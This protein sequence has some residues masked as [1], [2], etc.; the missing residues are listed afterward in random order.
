MDSV[1]EPDEILV[2]SIKEEKSIRKLQLITILIKLD[3]I[4]SPSLKLLTSW[5]SLP[6]IMSRTYSNFLSY[7]FQVLFCPTSENYS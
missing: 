4:F 7:S 6:T 1:M 3:C 2:I 5:L